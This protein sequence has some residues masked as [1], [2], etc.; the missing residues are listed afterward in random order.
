MKNRF[1]FFGKARR[2]FALLTGL[3]LSILS[4]SQNRVT[5]KILGPD[6]KPLIGVTVTAKGTNVATTSGADGVYSIV[7]PPKADVL[8]FSSVG[9]EVSEVNI[10]GHNEIDVAMKFQTTSLNEVV[11]TGYS[12]QRKKD[13]TGAVAVVNVNNLKTV[14][15]GTTESLLQGQASGV[16]VINSGVPGGGSNVRIRGITSVG[17]TDPLV[18]I[19]GTPGSLHDLNV[20][21]IESMQVLKDAGAASIYGV[22]G[23]NGV[24]VV[25]TKRG[26]SGKARITYDGYYGTQRPLS[27]GFAIA[28]PQ[29]TVNAIWAEYNNDGVSPSSLAPPGPAA[30]QFGQGA[31]PVIPDYITPTAGKVGDPNTDPSKYKLYTNQITKTNKEG[32]D[33]FHEVFKP[34]PIQS[35]SL[36][37]SGGSDKSSYYFSLGYFN[38]QG[39]LIE[40]YLKRYSARLNTVF[41]V[42][43]K[44]RIGEN[45]YA[46]YKQGPGFNNQNEGNTVSYDYRE[47]PLIPVYDIKGNYAGTNSKG[48]GNPQN[49]VANQL[50]THNNKFNDWQLNGNVFGE[51]DFLHH[52][53]VRTSFGGTVDNFYS[54]AFSYTQFE[55]AE[56]N[57]NPNAFAENVGY[58][59]SW[60]WTNTL[61]Y[62]NIFLEKHAV[63]ALV[64]T[65]AIQNYGRAI[66]GRRGNY[67]ITNPAD[68]T[69]DPNLWTLNFGPPSGQTTGN[70]G[71]PSGVGTPYQNSL[72]SLFGRVDYAYNDKYLVSGTIRRDGSSI[73]AEDNRYGVFPSFTGAWRIS[74]EDFMK[75]ITW[76]NDLKIRGGWG[77]LGSLSNTVSTNAFSLYNQTAANSYYDING[78]STSSTLGIYPSQ[79]GNVKASWEE[80]IVTNIGIDATILKN[81]LDFSVEWYKKDISGLLFR[82]TLPAVAG[83]ATAP[84]IN[85]GNIKNTGIDASATYHATVKRDLKIDVTGTFTS[86]KNEV[87]SLPPG[88]QYYDRNS[89]GSTRIGAFS[90]I[91]P[92]HPL[93]AFYGYQLVG[94]FQSAADVTNSPKQDGAEPGFLKYADISGPN[95]K[96]DGKIDVNDRTFFGNPNPKFNYGLNL[97]VTW[98]YL[99]FG[100]FLYGVS[101]NDVINYVKYWLDFPQVFDAAIG[102][103]VATNSWTPTNTGAKIPRLSRKANFSTSTAFSSYYMEKG[104]YL[105]CKT[106]T[107]GFTVPSAKISKYGIERIRIYA[108][109][110]NLFT[111]TDYTGLDPELTGSNLSDNTN[112]GIDFGNYP[113]NQKGYTIG[114][115]IAF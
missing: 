9:Y 11:V 21:D 2:I 108:Q 89:A 102:K 13:I 62:S 104:S 101:G 91:Q 107:L 14:P 80:D 110:L 44:I 29:E 20:N 98:K 113:S 36:A 23:S 38:Q 58:T 1:C 57:T 69:V 5:G 28:T 45:L 94:I 43:D 8:I 67:F 65:E 12:S 74:H 24:V 34:N 100:M 82:A 75:G 111:I 109:A 78:N 115:N 48:F 93:G 42:K 25:T 83:G 63:T 56:N 31:N 17:S 10:R 6:S 114:I 105:R 22:R 85:S 79:Q 95:G 46:F 3:S 18:I 27:E 52:F 30:G 19:D 106:M 84:F 81:K 47:S 16:T 103:D 49:P 37:V 64:G 51:V 70:V 55:N 96:P 88:I 86:Y 26:R 41:N 77:K 4:F 73:F 71:T 72:Y 76:L 99:D 92:G 32:T 112:F 59:S 87:V 15:S 68:L 90:R 7:M 50:R 35:H 39:T 54:S 40:T 97:A 53:T 33:W 60:T 61:K 66:Q